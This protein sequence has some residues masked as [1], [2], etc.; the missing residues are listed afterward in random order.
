MAGWIDFGAFEGVATILAGSDV[1]LIGGGMTV[2]IFCIA[3]IEYKT[4][5]DYV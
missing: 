1:G 5:N 2:S 4:Y 3:K